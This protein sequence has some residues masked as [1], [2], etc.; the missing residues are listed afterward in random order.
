MSDKKRR[1]D[2]LFNTGGAIAPKHPGGRPRTYDEPRVKVSLM[3]RRSQVRALEQIKND[4]RAR[5][6]KIGGAWRS[7]SVTSCV[8]EAIEQYI[9]SKHK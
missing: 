7:V 6:E 1:T 2:I 5:L 3:L 4:E 8:T 9:K